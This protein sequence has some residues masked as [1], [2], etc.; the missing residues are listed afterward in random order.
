VDLDCS[1]RRWSLR[2][3]TGFDDR[4]GALERRQFDREWRP[5]PASPDSRADCGDDALGVRKGRW[6]R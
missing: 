2:E 6:R 3:S 1:A 4:G 5:L